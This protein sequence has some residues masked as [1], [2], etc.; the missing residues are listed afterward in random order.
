LTLS[1]TDLL[2]MIDLRLSFHEGAS[3]LGA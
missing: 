3:A 2:L 1:I